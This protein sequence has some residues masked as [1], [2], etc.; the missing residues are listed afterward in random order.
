MNVRMSQAKNL[1]VL[2][3]DKDPVQADLI[4]QNLLTQGYEAET[5]SISDEGLRETIRSRDI[6]LI[7]IDAD[8]EKKSG[9]EFAREIRAENMA[10]PEIVFLSKDPQAHLFECH[11]VGGCQVLK[12]PLNMEVL[13]EL[14]NHVKKDVV[15]RRRYDRVHINP[16]AMGRLY[17]TVSKHPPTPGTTRTIEVSNIGR[18]GFFFEIPVGQ[19]PPT[20]GDILDFELKLSMLPEYTFK[21]QGIVRWTRSTVTECGAGVEFL[22]IPIE[23]E[24]LIR[25][26][27]E[28][29]KVRPFVPTGI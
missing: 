29:F 14:T 19:T 5:M 1:K 8:L 7:F 3:I 25:A 15:E 20:I 6:D 13:Q 28:L 18:G 9:F 23:S 10:L 2:V 16:V 12:K 27:V 26:F 17:G 4:V 11:Q 21:G 24:K 22:N